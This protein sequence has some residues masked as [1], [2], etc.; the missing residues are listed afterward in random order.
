MTA[1]PLLERRYRR[2]LLAYP[3]GYRRDHGD[4]LL[5]VLVE[6][7]APGRTR[8]P[9][10][11]AV[12]LLLGGAR[13]RAVA[14]ATGSPWVDGVHLGVTVVAM[15]NFM[16]LLPYAGALPMWS[17]L[18]AL[19]VLAILRGWIRTAAALTALVGLKALAVASGRQFGEMTLL[20]VHPSFL[21]ERALYG[22]TTPAAVISGYALVLAGLMLLAVRRPATLW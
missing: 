15:S 9:L 16:T 13:T 10:R 21:V 11:E 22:W 5:D 7:T 20:P 4:E 3:S 1:V 19:S 14:L 8:P 12:G 6:S 2:L 18:S 17:A